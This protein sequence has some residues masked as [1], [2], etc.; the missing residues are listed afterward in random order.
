MIKEIKGYHVL[1]AF[2]AFFGII[3]AVNTVFITAAFKSFSGEDVERSY[4]Q[5]LDY[6]QTLERRRAQDAMGWQAQVEVEAGEVL[7]AIQTQA[8]EPVTGLRLLGRL[9]HPAD[10]DNDQ[11]LEFEAIEPGL[12][13]AAFDPS[14][15]GQWRL[16]AQTGE[17]TPFDMEHAL[18]LD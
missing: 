9:R 8:G 5:G 13:R 6:N 3:I 12:Y 1:I 18:W 2:C 17:E 14:L 7:I 4:L 16:V 10:T 15:S 11:A